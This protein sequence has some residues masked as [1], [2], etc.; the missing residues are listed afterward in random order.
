MFSELDLHRCMRRFSLSYHE[1][2]KSTHNTDAQINTNVQEETSTTDQGFKKLSTKTMKWF[3][4][5]SVLTSK[6]MK[7]QVTKTCNLKN[8]SIKYL[9]IETRIQRISHRVLMTQDIYSSLVHS[10]YRK[11]F[12]FFLAIGKKRIILKCED[13]KKHQPQKEA[14]W[15]NTGMRRLDNRL[16][17]KPKGA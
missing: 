5:G 13:Y 3:N 7:E 2:Q 16:N 15:R 11:I 1:K 10:I 9:A 14:G 12:F 17:S 6:V 4:I 8:D